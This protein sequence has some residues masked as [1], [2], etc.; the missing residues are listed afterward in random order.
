MK[1][2][3]IRAAALAA[4]AAAAVLTTAARAEDPIVKP[5]AAPRPAAGPTVAAA[6]EFCGDA[7]GPAAELIS[8][9]SNDPKLKEVYKD[10]D[11]VAFSDDPKNSTVMYTFTTA[12]NPAHPAAVCRRPEKAGD[13]IVIKMVVVCDGAKDACDKLRNDFNVLTARMQVEADQ[14]LNQAKN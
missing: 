11:Y 7:S 8:R 2:A 9:Y 5:Q 1:F 6:Q 3:N 14:Q 10:N 13:N 12:T 4:L